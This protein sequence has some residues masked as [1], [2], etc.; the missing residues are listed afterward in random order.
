[1]LDTGNSINSQLLVFGGI[2]THQAKEDLKVQ[3]PHFTNER[4][5]KDNRQTQS[6]TAS[7]EEEGV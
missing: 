6:H 5:R 4:P 2:I 7:E 3:A 1:M